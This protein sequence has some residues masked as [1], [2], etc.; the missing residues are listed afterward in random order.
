MNLSKSD[1]RQSYQEK[2]WCQCHL[3][4]LLILGTEPNRKAGKH[5]QPRI[6]VTTRSLS[7]IALLDLLTDSAN[8]A[9][10]PAV[11][12]ILYFLLIK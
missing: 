4:S 9:A 1:I 8:N 12:T 3:R 6:E 5:G 11:K 10:W 2:A 7:S